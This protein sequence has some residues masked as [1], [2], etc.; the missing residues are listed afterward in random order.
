ML[1]LLL[2]QLLGAVLVLG[3]YFYYI[4]KLSN[5]VLWVNFSPAIQRLYW[6]SILLS[7]IA[8]TTFVL[9]TVLRIVNIR[10]MPIFIALSM[11]F[12]LA[13]A[14]WSPSLYYF[15]HQKWITALSLSAVSLFVLGMVLLVGMYEKH[16]LPSLLLLYLLFHVFFMDNVTWLRFYLV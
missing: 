5:A 7:A 9:L 15:P 1:L 10:Q 11:G 16:V 6:I 4:P 13:A 3:S 12:L 8:Y 14:T 2:S